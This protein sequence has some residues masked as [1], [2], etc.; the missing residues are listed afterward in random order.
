MLD[1]KKKSFRVPSRVVRCR[2]ERGDLSFVLNN[3]M[4]RFFFLIGEAWT[5]KSFTLNYLR[6]GN[7]F[8]FLSV[9]RYAS[10]SF[11]IFYRSADALFKRTEI[12]KKY[13][14]ISWVFLFL[15]IGTIL[16]NLAIFSDQVCGTLTK[17]RDFSFLL[18]QVV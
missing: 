9:F 5:R 1:K 16:K 10:P 11:K 4:T 18:T 3:C 14:S 8:F 2:G 12:R 17:L 15:A 13:N 6:E 7:F